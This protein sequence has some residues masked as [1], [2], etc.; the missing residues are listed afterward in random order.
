MIWENFVL[1]LAISEG[2]YFLEVHVSFYLVKVTVLKVE[3]IFL[4]ADV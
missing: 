1:H 3:F 2:E 4:I